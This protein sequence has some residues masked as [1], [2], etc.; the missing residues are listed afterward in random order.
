MIRQIQCLSCWAEAGHGILIASERA[1]GWHDRFN[2]LAP[3]TPKGHGITVNGVFEPL[4]SLM[5]DTCNNPLKGSAVVIAITLWDENRE[6]EPVLWEEDFGRILDQESARLAIQ[7][8]KTSE[9]LFW[10]EK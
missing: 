5:C 7:L 6:G 9:E 4:E 1:A 3:V 8:G 10:S 2:F